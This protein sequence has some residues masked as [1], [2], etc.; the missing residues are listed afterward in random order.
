[1]AENGAP[2]P[3]E[4]LRA[5]L[6]KIVFFEWRVSELQAELNS[7]QA[8]CAASEAGRVRAEEAV[9][10]ADHRARSLRMQVGELEAERARLASLL[11]RPNRGESE[12]LD[13]ER[14]CSERLR[15]SLEEAQRDL[16]RAGAERE[17]W[18]TEMAAQARNS[19]EA[20]AALAQ[21]ISELRN[22]IIRLRA[23]QAESDRLLQ[24]AGIAL[25]RVQEAA[26]KLP[27]PIET[28]A[29]DEAR[30]LWTQG[31]LGDQETAPPTLVEVPVSAQPLG[32]AARA[33]VDQ[34]VRNLSAR[35]AVRRQQAA[36]HLAAM[37]F[38]AAAPALATALGAERDAKARA[39]IAKALAACGR[40]GAADVVAALQAAGEVPLVRMAAAEALSGVPSRARGAV[41]TAAADPSPA[42]R[43][44]AAALAASLCFDDLL[45]SLA[46]DADASVRAAAA[47][48]QN[49]A[50]LPP[51]PAASDP[52]REAVQAVQAAIFGLTDKELAEHIGVAES[53]ASEIAVR[54]VAQGRLAR[55]GKRLIFAQGGAA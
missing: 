54:L 34:S 20:P 23:Y 2:S 36:R 47:A 12:A 41:E 30:K 44:R 37:A 29:V 50:A 22:E 17:R 3:A 13:A 28:G 45:G 49:D 43:R 14:S 9:S 6:E 48:A 15:A 39:Q 32:A 5:A 1:V 35:E 19:G 53:E 40:E 27:P 10:I 26:P 16:A 38:P 7:A 21:F 42:V 46:T 11:S 51:E 31:R 18:M 4:L 24:G 8:R 25:P 33:L 52:A 55:R